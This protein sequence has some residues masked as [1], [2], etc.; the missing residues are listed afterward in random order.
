M[1]RGRCTLPERDSKE[2]PG[3]LGVGTAGDL[4]RTGE[5]GRAGL[6]Q[7]PSGCSG[8]CGLS[9]LVSELVLE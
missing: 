6:A 8:V 4:R 1:P 9:L 2:V 5:I 3:Q 7:M